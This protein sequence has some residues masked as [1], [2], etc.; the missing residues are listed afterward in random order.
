[1]KQRAALISK[2]LFIETPDFLGKEAKIS[3]FEDIPCV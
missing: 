2:Q 1:M 3:R